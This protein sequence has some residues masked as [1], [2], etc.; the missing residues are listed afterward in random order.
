[1]EEATEKQDADDAP[2]ESKASPA[3]WH[4]RIEAAKEQ[5]KPSWDMAKM[6]F[7]E[8]IG[9][10]V[11]FDSENPNP[12]PARYPIYWSS[13]KNLQSMLY[14]RTPIPVAEKAFD[15][16][17][18]D[19]ARLACIDLERLAKYLIRS[20]AFDSTMSYMRDTYIHYGK[21]SCR[22]YFESE[23]NETAEKVYYTQI[24]VPAP[25]APPQDPSL[26][27]MPPPPPQMV[28]VNNKGE[29]PEDPSLL[30]QDE[31]GFYLEVA[32]LDRVCVEVCPLHYKD[33]LHNPDARWQEEVTWQSYRN[34]LTKSQFEKKFGKV[35][36]IKFEAPKEED[37]GS[38]SDKL[39]KTP[40]ATVWEIWDEENRELLFLAD[41]K[42]DAF[43][44][45]YL[46]DNVEYEGGDPY[47]LDGFFPSPNFILNNC[48][49]DSILP[50]P[51]YIQLRPLI[52]QIHGLAGKL[53]VHVKSLD[54]LGIYDA[55]VPGLKA[56]L[57]G[58]RSGQFAALENFA[59]LIDDGG[60][61]GLEKIL[62]FFPMKEIAEVVSLLMQAIEAYEAKF[63]E[64]WGLPDII[65]G[66]NNPDE[67]YQKQQ[68]KGEWLSL[69]A[70]VPGRAFQ[71]V[72]RDAIEMMCDL[73]LKMF[74]EQKLKDIMGVNYNTPEDQALWPQRLQLLR[75][76]DE[77]KVRI[78]IETDSTITMNENAQL[79]Q[80]NYTAKIITDGFASIAA[81][82]QQDPDFAPV[83][84]QALMDVVTGTQ[85]GK[86]LEGLLRQLQKKKLEQMQNPAPPPPDPKIQVE[87][88][89]QEGK[90]RE[91]QGKQ[92]LQ[93]QKQE[94]EFA[95]KQ[96][97]L[98]GQQAI[99]SIQAQA[100]I[101]T[102]MA[103]IQAEVQQS[104]MEGAAKIEIEKTL[105]ELKGQL[106]ILKAGLKVQSQKHDM[107]V[108]EHDTAL[109]AGLE[110]WNT[111]EAIKL[112]KE[113][114]KNAYKQGAP[115]D[116]KDA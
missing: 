75:D 110:V 86:N 35:E 106:E 64:I 54:T 10:K 98:E 48:G 77:R 114:A 66:A 24:E 104:Q 8:Y 36:G 30:K 45:P 90:A 16:L 96:M 108:K 88:M 91:V 67:G 34:V 92:I 70:T 4:S 109:N 55:G 59:E 65:Q 25:P 62:R 5:F 23:I 95:L 116:S 52:E 40:T 74:P 105:A 17:D 20:C 53:Q 87:Q 78:N 13:V 6:A 71:R 15:D 31:N 115:N 84:I 37:R 82:T 76:D 22:I 101:E 85:R 9:P 73:A 50:V 41:G 63:R 46:G 100:D 60:R 99:E 33:N 14:S 94:G 39:P 111:N 32:G 80:R 61:P 58:V 89:K 57:E 68:Q 49:P 72:V 42:K 69:R 56:T 83:G 3:L 107:K 38:S 12:P 113:Q 81:M 11:K 112:S 28:W 7:D 29:S 44:T 21:A 97:E 93:A 27:P 79:E 2:R 47:E 19:I 51:D 26:P 103:K 18:D 102:T 1:M 43:L